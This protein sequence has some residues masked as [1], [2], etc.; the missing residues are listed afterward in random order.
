MDEL[1]RIILDMHMM[2]TKYLHCIIDQS[3]HFPA[4][5]DRM[6]ELGDLVSHREI[7]IEV[8]LAIEYTLFF[9]TTPQSMTRTN[10]EIDDSGRECRKHPR[11]AHTDWTD[12][13]VWLIGELERIHTAAEHFGMRLDT[14]MS[15][16][17]HDD[18]VFFA[19]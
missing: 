1:P 12:I 9:D 15:L 16:E 3:L 6:I 13:D 7:W 8:A 5:R 14:D 17:T 18:F 11:E 2:D 19:I 4:I 10:S